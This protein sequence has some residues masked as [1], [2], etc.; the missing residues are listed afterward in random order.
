MSSSF[1]TGEYASTA[2]WLLYPRL[3]SPAPVLAVMWYTSRS[4]PS[5]QVGARW[6]STALPRRRVG[7]GLNHASLGRAV[8]HGA[9]SLDGLAVVGM[10][11]TVAPRLG[12]VG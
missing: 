9:R 12:G 1:I 5:I 6:T 3:A 10:V 2:R 4:L 8:G 11:V 7:G